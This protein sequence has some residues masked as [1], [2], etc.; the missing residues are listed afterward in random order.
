[1][2]RYFR[3]ICVGLPMHVNN[4]EQRAVVDHLW[5]NFTERLLEGRPSRMGTYFSWWICISCDQSRSEMFA[6]FERFTWLHAK[7]YVYML[8]SYTSVCKQ[9][10]VCNVFFF[11]LWCC[12]YCIPKL[13]MNN[14]LLLLYT[15]RRYVYVYVHCHL[16]LHILAQRQSF[17][18][19]YTAVFEY[20]HLMHKFE[21][22]ETKNLGF[23]RPVVVSEVPV[24]VAWQRNRIWVPAAAPLCGFDMIGFEELDTGT[25][26]RLKQVDAVKCFSLSGFGPTFSYGNWLGND[27][28]QSKPWFS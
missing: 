21:K 14:C 13:K 23:S 19:K 16:C 25:S 15:C 24:Y 7:I 4:S 22:S 1:M 3:R 11:V 26:A 10:P 8:F 2:G 17:C 12:P 20:V 6:L 28:F 18:N 5:P 9:L 27:T